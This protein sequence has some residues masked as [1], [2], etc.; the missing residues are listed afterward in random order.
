MGVSLAI[1]SGLAGCVSVPPGRSAI[2]EVTIRGSSAIDAAEISDK[3]ATASS[4]KFLGLFRGVVYDYE[5]FDPTVLQRDLARIERFYRGKGFLEAH[6]RAGRVEEVSPGHVRVEIVVDEGPPIL[7]RN[8]KFEGNVNFFLGRALRA[9]VNSALPV[10]DRFDEQAYDDARGKLQKAL[11]D[12]GYAYATVEASASIDPGAKAAD[13]VFT[14]TPGPLARF[15]EITFVGL[16]PDG[17]GPRPQEIEEAPLRRAMN[18]DSGTPYSTAEID[19]AVQALLDL[20]VFSAVQ[21]EPQLPQPPPEQP[22]VPLVVHVEPTR[23]RQVRLGFGA[24]FDE[25]KTDLHLLAGWEDHNFLGGLRD[26][27]VDFRPGV[28]LYPLRLGNVVGPSNYLLEE[29]LRLQ[30]RQPSFLEARTNAFIKPEFNVYPFLVQANPPADQPVVGFIEGKGAIG[31]E[32][33]FG[34]ASISLA[35]NAQLE[36]PF[37]YTGDGPLPPEIVLSYPEL[38]TKLDL[39]DDPIHPRSGIYLSNSLQVAGEI[40]GGSA[41]DFRIQPEAR[42]YVPLTRKLTLAARGSVGF[43]F[44][45]NYHVT[46]FIAGS[47]EGS[48]A[49]TTAIETL[50]FRGFFSGGPNSNRGFPIRGVAP[51]GTVPFLLP[52]TVNQQIANG[53][54]TANFKASDCAIPIAGYSL[55]EF[56]TELRYQVAGPFSAALFCDMGDASPDQANLRWKHLHLSCGVGARYDTPVGPIRLDVGY[57]VQPLQVVGFKNE[58]DAADPTKGGQPI[59]GNPPDLFGAV[60]MAIAFGIGEAY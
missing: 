40:F 23:L 25:I 51:Y 10:G 36:H 34:K 41:S 13:Y 44:A 53:C 11:T 54:S 9:T 33:P 37:E 22:I 17:K 6:A 20:E 21:I 27:S 2:D 24:E 42:G 55:W 43:L 28:V 58:A 30:F 49:R 8:V 50:Y 12:L 32:R 56:S 26:F 29:R 46:D 19:T 3:I 45:G 39:R 16:D 38:I 14:V 31:V 48:A 15:G 4:E 52:A 1:A 35:Y 59:N 18:I 7:N 47:D 60:P 5:V 57:R